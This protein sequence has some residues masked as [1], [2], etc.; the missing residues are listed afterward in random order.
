M[1]HAHYIRVMAVHSLAEGE[2]KSRP[3][4]D[5]S[6]VPQVVRATRG[7]ARRRREARGLL[8][9]ILPATE[10]SAAKG[11]CLD[12]GRVPQDP[13]DPAEGVVEL[14]ALLEVG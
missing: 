8:V 10:G 9:Q 6:A 4:R 7:V 14:F 13:G 12:S 1:S 5:G 2:A 11:A 3:E